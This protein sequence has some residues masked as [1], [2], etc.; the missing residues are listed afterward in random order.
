M[1]VVGA[2]MTSFPH[3]VDAD[4][5]VAKVER[6]MDERAIR[7]LP[8]Q[9]RGRVVG[10]VS[11]RDL[12]HFIK[13]SAPVEEKNNVRARDIMVA[14]PYVVSFNT[15]LNEVVSEMAQRHIGSAIVTRSGKLAGV[16]SAN[17]VCRILGEYLE[18]RFGADGG[19]DAA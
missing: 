4:D 11:E 9:E 12:H 10:I 14:D 15:P 2:V 5:T 3:F 8:V 18:S 7:H 6:L 13:R 1:P 19:D 16:L 17:D